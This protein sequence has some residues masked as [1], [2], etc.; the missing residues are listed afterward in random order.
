MVKHTAAYIQETPEQ[1]DMDIQQAVQAAIKA[2]VKSWDLMKIT[3]R[4]SCD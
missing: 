3:R 4:I 2:L 1:N